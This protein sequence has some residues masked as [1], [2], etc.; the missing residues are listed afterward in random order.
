MKCFI[1]H[2]III[3]LIIVGAYFNQYISSDWKYTWGFLIGSSVQAI[4]RLMEEQEK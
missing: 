4:Y 2:L 1:K 3:I